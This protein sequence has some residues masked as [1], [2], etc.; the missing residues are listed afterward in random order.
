MSD[1]V[2][3][4]N[5]LH[6]EVYPDGVPSLVPEI[7]KI[8]QLIKF[9]KQNMQG[10]SYRP[11]VRLAL[12]GGFTPALGDGT[13]G[14]FSLNDAKAGI[15]KKATVRGT[16]LILR[17]QMSYEDA[18][19]AK[20]GKQSFVQGTKFFY[21]GMQK[22]ARKRLEIQLLY[23]AQGIGTV[24]T[25]TSGDPSIVIS[26]ATWAPQIWAGWEGSE[27][28][29]QTA[30]TSSVRGTVTIVSIDIE[31][32]KITLSGTVSGCAAGDLIFFKGCFAKEMTGIRGILANTGT[33]FGISASTYSMWKPASLALS[34]AALSFNAVK[35]A[36]AASV[37]KGLDEEITLLCNPNGWDDLANDIL[38][39]RTLDKSEVRKVEVGADEIVYRAQGVRCTVLP[40]PMVKGGDAFGLAM[41]QW[42]RIGA[43]DVQMGA[44][45]FEDQAFFHL[46]SKAGVES[47]M[48]SNQCIYAEMPAVNFYI[49][50]I[51]NTSL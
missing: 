45:G 42:K 36:I 38:Q 44:P 30:A 29:V 23:G 35:K 48:Y 22:A 3:N 17:D 18:G 49:S 24:Q 1:V 32:R 4:L 50:G 7:A 51:V 9:D 12:P 28:D 20:G 43:V 19:K 15:V 26:L 31:N 37:G 46:G 25:Y 11:S 33:L 47:R 34:S 6:K 21:E 16:Q 10:D 13:E 2:E 39:L 5:D 40:H 14:A 27:I 41:S 8:Q